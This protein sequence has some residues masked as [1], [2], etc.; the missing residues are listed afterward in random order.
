MPKKRPYPP[1]THLMWRKY[2]LER[3]NYVCLQCGGKANEA[4]HEMSYI[5]HPDLRLDIS[6][7][8]SLCHSCHKKEHRIKEWLIE[9]RS[10]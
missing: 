5:N 2:V 9:K 8:I 6:N 7:G 10:R 4:H 1:T 3:D